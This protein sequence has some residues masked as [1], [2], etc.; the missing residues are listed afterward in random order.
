MN[1]N[2]LVIILAVLIVVAGAV[3]INISKP[4]VSA[5]GGGAL[6]E[7]YT[8]EKGEKWALA[9]EG[10]YVFQVSSAETTGPKFLEGEIDPM[11]VRPGDVQKM[12]V[13]AQSS[14]GIKS[15]VADI[16]TDNGT[17]TVPLQKTGIITWNKMT[18]EKYVVENGVLKAL[19]PVQAQARWISN[20]LADEGFLSKNV[21]RAASGDKEIWE[22]SWTVRDT[23]VRTY[24]TVFTATD[25][26]GLSSQLILAWSD[27]CSIPDTNNSRVSYVMTTSCTLGVGESDGWDGA[28][29]QI[30]GGAN[31]TLG[32]NAHFFWNPGQNFY[33]AG[34]N[35]TLSGPGSSLMQ[36]YLFYYDVDDDR[37]SINASL[38]SSDASSIPNYVRFYYALG[39]NDCFQTDPATTNAELAFPGQ[40]SYFPTN[41]GDGSYDYNCVN[42]EEELWP[43]VTSCPGSASRGWVGS[44]PA[45]G[46]TATY[47]PLIN[48]ADNDQRTQVC[49]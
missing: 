17:T 16:E 7:T 36:Q 47:Y 40:T 41:R 21:A 33:V 14:A 31:L 39:T 27:P 20:V 38:T 49:H 19:S 23:H 48:C 25:N 42:G 3:L 30:S 4:Q 13:I 29:F 35:V 34:G 6:G 26:N 46:A 43:L 9:A 11:D 12:K 10:E 28:D 8:N 44:V 45:C 5:P 18:P 37:Y 15:V 32:Q 2:T 24:H 1:K 22:G